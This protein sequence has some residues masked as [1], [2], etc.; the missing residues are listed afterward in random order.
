MVAVLALFAAPAQAEMSVA[1]FITKADALEA[2]GILAIGS[3]DI[4]LLK[5]EIKTAGTAYRTDLAANRAGGKAPHS[6][7]PPQGKA[8]IGSD[9]LLAHMRTY[10]AQQRVQVSVKSAFYAMMKKRYPCR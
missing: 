3:S 2:K 4:G 5:A 1:T 9:E 6:C 8:K 7:P 10:P